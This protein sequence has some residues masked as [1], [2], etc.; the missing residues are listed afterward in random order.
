[1]DYK[2]N[3]VLLQST[4]CYVKDNNGKK[5]DVIKGYF[6]K[7]L[8]RSARN[9]EVSFAVNDV[10]IDIN[11]VDMQK[12][13]NLSEPFVTYVLSYHMDNPYS[14]PVVT[15]LEIATDT[16]DLQNIKISI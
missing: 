6:N 1:M 15:A 3:A 14:P 12:A 2:V 4:T 16:G 13:V 8:M 5:T 10:Y 7:Y 11:R 9:G